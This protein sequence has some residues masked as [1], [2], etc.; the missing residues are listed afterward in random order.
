MGSIIQAIKYR[1]DRRPYSAVEDF[2]AHARHVRRSRGRQFR[3]TH[4]PEDFP[5]RDRRGQCESQG[6]DGQV[7]KDTSYHRL[8]GRGWNRSHERG[9][10]GELRTHQG[11]SEPNCRRRTGTN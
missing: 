7:S 2:D 10:A 8:H 5:R 3:R 9:G 6:R 11:R 4:R 1:Q